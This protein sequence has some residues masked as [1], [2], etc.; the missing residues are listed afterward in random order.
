MKLL[1]D[2][3]WKKDTYTIGIMYVN[4]TRFSETCEDKDRGLKDSM[5]ETEIKQKKMYGKTAIPTGTYKIALTHS[6]KF[7]N[8]PFSKKYG[9]KV[10]EIL[11]VKGYKG[12]R[13]H[14]FNT[15]EDSL[16]CIAVGRNLE[17]GKVLQ[18]TAYYYKLMDEYIVPALKRG[19]EITITIK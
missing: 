9:N 7:A 8:R 16:G 18:S 11:N 15:A 5:S 19:E 6:P 1:V 17:K 3:K 10:V 14:P 13:I 2:R 12:I 4:G